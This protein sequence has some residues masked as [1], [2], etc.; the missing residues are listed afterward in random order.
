MSLFQQKNNLIFK[1][2]KAVGSVF[3]TEQR[4][5]RSGELTCYVDSDRQLWWT[6]SQRLPALTHQA[7]VAPRS[8]N[9]KYRNLCSLFTRQTM[10]GWGSGGGPVYHVTCESRAAL[11]HLLVH[12]TRYYMIFNGLAYRN[13]VPA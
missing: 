7:R 4:G 13:I 5:M 3:V 11:H 2:T 9:I 1:W 8:H 6:T 10:R 12:N